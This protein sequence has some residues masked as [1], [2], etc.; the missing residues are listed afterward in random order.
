MRHFL[1]LSVILW[2]LLRLPAVDQQGCRSVEY[3][4][5]LLLNDPGLA[6]RLLDIENFTRL[7][8]DHSSVTVTGATGASQ[9]GKSVTIITIP[10][11]VHIIYNNSSRN[12][13]DAQVQ[14]QIAVLN[15]DYGKQNPD[16]SKIPAYYTDL[17][18]VCGFRFALANVDTNGNTTT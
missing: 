3:N 6:T 11:V 15:R 14:S 7:H 8:L 17:A 16:T 18:A 13:S 4:Q 12:I 5:D 9:N 10:V 2:L 1:R